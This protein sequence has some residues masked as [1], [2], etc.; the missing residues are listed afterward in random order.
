MKR[1]TY[2]G[3][4]NSSICYSELMQN[5]AMSCLQDV[6]MNH[7]IASFLLTFIHFCYLKLSVNTIYYSCI[8][9]INLFFYINF[10]FAF[11]LTLVE[12]LVLHLYQ[13]WY[14]LGD[15]RTLRQHQGF[16]Y[17]D[18]NMFV[19]LDTRTLNNRRI[20]TKLLSIN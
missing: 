4:R 8:P 12:K 3:L 15:F 16:I 14:T 13:V 1:T 9:Y 7:D 6:P 20:I 19:E 5:T 11:G 17:R 10:D 2:S 18:H